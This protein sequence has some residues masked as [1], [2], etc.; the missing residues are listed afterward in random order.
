MNNLTV[1]YVDNQN[2]Y[3][4]EQVKKSAE[5]FNGFVVDEFKHDGTGFTVVLAI[6][7]QSQE[8]NFRSDVLRM[9]K[10]LNL[11]V[12]FGGAYAI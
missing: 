5:N 2:K 7:S 6:P 1:T 12:E 10:H 11:K 3:F 4:E 9:A 8:N